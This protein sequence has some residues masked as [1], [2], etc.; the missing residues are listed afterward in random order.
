MATKAIVVANL[1]T[2]LKST[3]SDPLHKHIPDNLPA[4]SVL[5][6]TLDAADRLALNEKERPMLKAILG[7]L[8]Y[9]ART[10]RDVLKEAKCGTVKEFEEKYLTDR[11]VSSTALWDIS[12]IYKCLPEASLED[13][14]EIGDGKLNVAVKAL[15]ALGE[16]S[17]A[18]RQEFL[19][20]AK[21]PEH[22]TV[23]KFR[24]WVETR[25]GVSHAGAT[26]TATITLI[27]SKADV[28][29][30]EGFFA[31]KDA[32]EYLNSKDR[33]QMTLAAFRENS[34]LWGAEP[35]PKDP[36]AELIATALERYEE[37]GRREKLAAEIMQ[38]IEDEL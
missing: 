5:K 8:M 2:I 23:G 36:R 21:N 33:L 32:Q 37:H 24:T 18:Q 11:G 3:D 13:V 17:A 16:P 25:S 7:R 30:Q 38:A 15:S 27:G 19:D 4:K 29:E 10:N 1:S 28:D 12:R 31:D 22:D 9:L 6:L 20:E 34:S 26:E 14:A 35:K